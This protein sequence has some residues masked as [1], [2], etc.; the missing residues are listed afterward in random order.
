MEQGSISLVTYLLRFKK[1]LYEAG[2]KTWPDNAKII[3]LVGGLNK[4][5]K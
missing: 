4:E 3:T 2:A 5:V 1:T